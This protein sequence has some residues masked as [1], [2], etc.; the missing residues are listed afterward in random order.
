[1]GQKVNP[2]GY[3]L[4][5]KESYL[6]NWYNTKFNYSKLSKLDN[7]II[8]K[9][10]S[11]LKNIIYLSK[12]NLKQSFFKNRKLNIILIEIKACLPSLSEI[13]IKLNKNL[14]KKFLI[15]LKLIKQFKLDTEK[16]IN[17]FF[18]F[19]LKKQIL[20]LSFLFYKNNNKL[21]IFNFNF[22]NNLF[23]TSTLIANYIAENIKN[24]IPF[25][26][27]LK[28]IENKLELN[29]IKGFKIQIAGRLNGAE[30][31]RTEWQKIGR[32]PLHTLNN[33]ID[34]TKKKIK[35]VFGIIGIKVW[36]YIF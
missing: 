27:I 20:K 4:I 15:K 9:I 21:L 25:R 31:A 6:N 7:I 29:N 28:Q 13:L 18:N 33:F 14:E 26:R 34:Y 17:I 35:T 11:N 1:M 12:I 30:I 24:R 19:F 10:N 5:I 23:E 3:R 2:T 16:I 36:I 22:N 8:K 32:I